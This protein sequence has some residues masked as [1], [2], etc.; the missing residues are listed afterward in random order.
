MGSSNDEPW[1]MQFNESFL[2]SYPEKPS[3]SKLIPP[4]MEMGAAGI[5]NRAPDEIIPYEE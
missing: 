5:T 1:A 2:L 4:K 3:N